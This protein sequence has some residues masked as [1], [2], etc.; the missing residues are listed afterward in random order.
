MYEKH[1]SRTLSF[2]HDKVVGLFKSSAEIG[3]RPMRLQR[4]GAGIRRALVSILKK[5]FGSAGKTP[6]LEEWAR[7]Q[8]RC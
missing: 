5:A 6:G 7:P 4:R 3:T 1:I 2:M 8:R